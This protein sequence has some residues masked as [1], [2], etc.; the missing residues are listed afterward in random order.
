MDCLIFSLINLIDLLPYLICYLAYLLSIVD[1]H[2]CHS[3]KLLMFRVCRL[4]DKNLL[5]P[6]PPSLTCMLIGIHLVTFFEIP[7]GL[8]FPLS[9][10]AVSVVFVSNLYRCFCTVSE[11]PVKTKIFSLIYSRLFSRYSPQESII[12]A[13]STEQFRL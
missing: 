6:R 8:S 4:L 11:I 5:Y 13:V 2:S 7:F 9:N 3:R 10:M 12:S 1:H